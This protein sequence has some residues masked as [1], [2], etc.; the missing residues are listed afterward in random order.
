VRIVGADDVI[1]KSLGDTNV[2]ESDSPEGMANAVNTRSWA[3]T[4]QLLPPRNSSP[5]KKPVPREAPTVELPMADPSL[6]VAELVA[7]ARVAQRK[8]E[9]KLQSDQRIEQNRP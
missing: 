8:L 3:D 1:Q 2:V 4:H 6:V 9:P 7:V 5:A